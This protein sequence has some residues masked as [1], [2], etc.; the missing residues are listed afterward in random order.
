MGT[1]LKITQNDFSHGMQGEERNKNLVGQTQVFGASLVKHF[2]IYQDNNALAPNPSFEKWNTTAEEK[3]GIVA[4]DAD[5]DNNIVVGLGSAISNWSDINSQYRIKLE[6][7]TLSESI[8]YTIVDLSILGNDFWDVV[9]ADGSD[10]RV[11]TTDNEV[12]TRTII[13]KFDKVAKTGYALCNLHTTSDLHVYFGSSDL[14]KQAEDFNNFFN[15]SVDFAY[16][17]DGTVQDFSGNNYFLDRT[18][19]F[20]SGNIL[21]QALGNQYQDTD[22]F[23]KPQ[24]SVSISFFFKWN[25]GSKN[26][27]VSAMYASSINI[28]SDGTVQFKSTSMANASDDF[29]L[30]STTKL[31]TNDWFHINGTVNSG[32]YVSLFINGV[33]EAT[34]AV[35]SGLTESS[36][37][38]IM[39]GG[40]F[41]ELVSIRNGGSRSKQ[42]NIE[43][44]LMFADA[45]NY[46]TINTR[47]DVNSVTLIQSGV[48]LYKKS[49]NG[50]EWSQMYANGFVLADSNP[51]YSPVPG[52][53]KYTGSSTGGYIFTTLNSTNNL[54]Y[55]SRSGGFILSPFERLGMIPLS[56]NLFATLRKYLPT[57]SYPIDKEHYIGLGSVLNNFNTTDG[58]TASIFNPFGSETV[59]VPYGY[60]LA[61]AGTR[62]AQG[63]IEL[64]DLTGLDPETVIKTDT[65]DLNAILNESGNLV[66]VHNVYLE[67][68]ELSRNEPSMEFRVWEGGEDVRTFQ[69]F[70]YE[71][72]SPVDYASW[73]QP[74]HPKV[75]NTAG[76]STFYAEPKDTQAGMWSVGKTSSGLAVT[77]PYDTS[78]YEYIQGYTTAGNNLIIVDTDNK[79]YKINSSNT[80]SQTSEFESMVIDA[81]I[82]GIQKNLI[83]I[84]VSLSDTP[85]D[86]QVQVYYSVDGGAYQYV[87]LCDSKHTEFGLADGNPFGSFNE[88]KIKITSSGGNVEITEY[89]LQVEYEE[90]MI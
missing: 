73:Q 56:E 15:N 11:Y 22:A 23:V 12:N 32:N 38:M 55:G 5:Y 20:V 35:T 18:P 47:E 3:L 80:Y 46:W 90:E 84:E 76:S 75:V 79:I 33:E 87:G 88:V 54:I 61:I 45:S 86:Q 2:D 82:S 67:E 27:V 10:V 74:I 89:S 58:W 77:I 57:S 19:A 85:G 25:G 29:N 65:G 64:W 49:F 8:D 50:S 4:L 37:P 70:E 24:S 44:G 66:T 40:G 53:V 63:Y 48:A 60:S 34:V 51:D 16:T 31:N 68:P 28:L 13:T 43:Q 17:L 83:G 59:S 9:K 41:K 81:G 71:T 52:F 6:P 62:D 42:S 78:A 72:I 1:R 14:E 36:Q 69:K 30:N 39:T 21:D 26:D 7:Q